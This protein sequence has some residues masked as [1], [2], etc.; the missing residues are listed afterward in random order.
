M[1]L[2]GII[3][4]YIFYKETL[5][6]FCTSE[7]AILP[8][9]QSP[10]AAGYDLYSPKDILIPVGKQVK[11]NM[12]IKVIFPNG[13]YGQITT[14]S[15]LATKHGL[16]IPTGVIDQDYCGEIYVVIGNNG[17]E[18]YCIQK[19][20]RIAQ[21]ILQCIKTPKVVQILVSTNLLILLTLS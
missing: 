9:R 15:S 14:R 4:S 21:L 18:D 7:T 10:G 17:S 3:Y 8:Q 16:Y 1:D 2:F 19:G 13:C 5:Q 11:I 6:V 20:E 12:K